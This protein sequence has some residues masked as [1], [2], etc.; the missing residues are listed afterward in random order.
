MA[1]A[2]SITTSSELLQKLQDTVNQHIQIQ[3]PGKD[4]CIEAIEK[5]GAITFTSYTQICCD[6]QYLIIL[7][8][9]DGKS[10]YLLV[11]GQ[12]L[13]GVMPPRN[14]YEAILTYLDAQGY[15]QEATRVEVYKLTSEALIEFDILPKA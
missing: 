5:D 11:P 14:L 4:L 7:R 3:Q 1:L 10:T 12:D 8:P 6:K 13:C 2:N 15:N 9:Q